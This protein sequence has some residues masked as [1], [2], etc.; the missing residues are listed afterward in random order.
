[1]GTQMQSSVRSPELILRKKVFYIHYIYLKT[2]FF[3]HAQGAINVIKK[4]MINICSAISVCELPLDS[5]SNISIPNHD[6]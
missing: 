3:Q 5:G 4:L 6:C 1:M 2:C